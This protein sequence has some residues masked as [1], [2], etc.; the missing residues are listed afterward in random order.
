MR[1]TESAQRADEASL[2]KLTRGFEDMP[3]VFCCFTCKGS[4]C[5]LGTLALSDVRNQILLTD[6]L[7][8]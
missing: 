3:S 8:D 5:V 2:A 4:I 6:F 7:T 1:T